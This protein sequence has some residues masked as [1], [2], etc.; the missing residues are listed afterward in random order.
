MDEKLLDELIP[1]PTL[2]EQREEIVTQLE[3]KGFNITRFANG[4]VFGT[5]LLIFCQIRIDILKLLRVV[6]KALFVSSAPDKWLDVK[7]NDYSKSRKAATKAQGKLTI[8]RTNVEDNLV[9]PKGYIF[10]TLPS[11]AGSEYRF[12]STERVIISKN[13]MSGYIPVAAEDVGSEYNVPTNSI[14]RSVIHIEGIDD[15]TNEDNWLISEGADEEETEAFRQ[16]TLNSWAELSTTP[17]AAK[18]KNVAESVEGVLY[19]L[20]D[21]MHPR[22]QGSVD[23]IVAS[24][25]GTAGEELLRKVEMACESI[26]GTYDNLLIKSADTVLQDVELVLYLP[27]NINDEGII[28]DAINYTREYFKVSKNRELNTLYTSELIFHVRKNIDI[29]KGI[30]VVQP[31]SDQVL[32]KDKVIILGEVNVTIERV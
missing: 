32:S 17:I 25:A 19:V 5:I 30:K 31:S 11:I 3:E 26:K 12:F 9:I 2:E 4:S 15:I 14:K 10:K 29:L 21:D 7:A 22:G 1:I 27:Y 16:R 20:V 8:T 23:I 13:E 6:Y 28:E 18:Y 24:Y